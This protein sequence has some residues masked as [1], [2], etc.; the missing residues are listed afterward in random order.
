MRDLQDLTLNLK[1][2]GQA[3]K[4]KTIH[5]KAVEK[6]SSEDT[7]LYLFHLKKKELVQEVSLDP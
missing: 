6:E 1:V 5:V 4:T 3:K 2:M 7:L